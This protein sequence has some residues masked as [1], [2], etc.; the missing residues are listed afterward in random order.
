M[1]KVGPVVYHLAL[2]PHLHKVYNVFHESV[3]RYYIADQYHNIQWKELWVS[4]EGII[5]VKP[6]RILELRV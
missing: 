4:D 1:E 2:P 5:L 3:L 6:F